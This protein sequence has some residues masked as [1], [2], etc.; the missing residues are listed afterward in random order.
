MDTMLLVSDTDARRQL[1]HSLRALMHARGW[2][3]SELAKQFGKTRSWASNLLNPTKATGTTLATVDEI[4]AFVSKNYGVNLD[5]SDLFSPHNLR[6]KLG[7][8]TQGGAPPVTP[9]GNSHVGAGTHGTLGGVETDRFQRIEARFVQLESIMFDCYA[10]LARYY[11]PGE[12][13]STGDD[14]GAARPAPHAAGSSRA[15]RR[16]RKTSR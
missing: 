12:G 11:A 2:N 1:A 5:V 10:T 15:S 13:R 14:R 8:E 6:I 16:A 4:R 3:Q 7:M 9:S